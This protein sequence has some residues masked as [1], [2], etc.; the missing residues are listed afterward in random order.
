M[1]KR[2]RMD[3]KEGYKKTIIIPK[4]K[5][6]G[7]YEAVI[8]RLLDII[9]SG[10]AIICLSWLMLIVYVLVRIN[11]GSP[12]IFVQ[13]R[14]GKNGKIFKLYKFRSMSNATDKNGNLLPAKQR[15][16]RFGKILR[17][18]S[19]DELPELINILKGDM[20]IV[21]P[22]PLVAEYLDYYNE[23]DARRHE[24]LPGLTGFAQVSGRNAITWKD[25]FRKDVEYVDNITFLGDVKIV[26]LTVKK[27]FKREG[28]EFLEGHQSVMEYFKENADV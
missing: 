18:T 11:L 24:V 17:S 27:I 21:G 22:R 13:K 1:M 23:R 5:I 6:K 19:L 15:L 26:L 4:H 12:A 14:A 8:K 25:K 2:T 7:I 10:L 9:L 20:S 16:N 3:S 28:I